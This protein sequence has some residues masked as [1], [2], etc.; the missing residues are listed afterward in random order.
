M[1]K[2][3]KLNVITCPHCGMEYLPAEIFVDR[4]FLGRP[5]D[6]ERDPYGKILTF[7]DKTL[8]V[9]EEYKCDNCG[10]EFKVTAK[11]SFK[12]FIDEDDEFDTEYVSP[13]KE[14]KLTLFED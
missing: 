10:R 5:T 11:V 12:S 13:L 1:K 8:D 4:A 3:D 7:Q 6:I 14:K 2:S 9:N